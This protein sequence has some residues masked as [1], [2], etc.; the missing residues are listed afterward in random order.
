[1]VA[2]IL[3]LTIALVLTLSACGVLWMTLLMPSTWSAFV[4]RENAWWV[5]AGLLPEKW[6][7]M[8]KAMET[9]AS[10]KIVLGLTIAGGLTVLT[11]WR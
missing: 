1:M 6:A 4:E 10:L 2:T 5:R 9:G 8:L 7:T 3:A 11:F